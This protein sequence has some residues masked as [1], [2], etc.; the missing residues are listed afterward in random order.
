MG[1]TH[2]LYF[3]ISL[4][5]YKIDMF[6]AYFKYGKFWQAVVVDL[7]YFSP[8][9]FKLMAKSYFG[10]LEPWEQKIYKEIRVKHNNSHK[11][12]WEHYV[13]NNSPNRNE[14]NYEVAEIRDAGDTLFAVQGVQDKKILCLLE[15]EDKATFVCSRVN[16]ICAKPFVEMPDVY[17][18]LMIKRWEIE[19]DV[20]A[21]LGKYTCGEYSLP[22]KKVTR[23]VEAMYKD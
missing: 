1:I 8:Y 22:V 17:T 3:L 15:S 21:K 12:H 5:E 4:I 18:A 6:Y 7:D 10:K 13:I 20:Y 16:L 19:G 11:D 2:Y 14:V 23:F 9:T